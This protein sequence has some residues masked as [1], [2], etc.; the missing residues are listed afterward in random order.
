MGKEKENNVW[1]REIKFRAWVWDKMLNNIWQLDF[2]QEWHIEIKVRENEDDLCPTNYWCTWK[3]CI[4]WAWH[5]LMQYTWLKDK[6]WVGIFEGDIVT[7]HRWYSG[8]HEVKE[9]DEIVKR[10]YNGRH[11]E[12]GS[13]SEWNDVTV[14]W[15]IYQWLTP[16]SES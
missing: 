2:I 6:N 12:N 1:Q 8:D 11:L 13:D 14:I 4:L 15:N 5:I 16:K 3:W 9:H 7:V 10:D